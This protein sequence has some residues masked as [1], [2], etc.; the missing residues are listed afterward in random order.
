MQS[1]LLTVALPL[2]W[3][4]WRKARLVHKKSS[5]S[6]MI[7]RRGSADR[8]LAGEEA[9]ADCL[10]APSASRKPLPTSGPACSTRCGDAGP[11]RLSDLPRPQG[12]RGVT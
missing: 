5:K 12:E 1:W 7:A 4:K 8:R 11:K 9:L 2:L 3:T 10:H 6:L